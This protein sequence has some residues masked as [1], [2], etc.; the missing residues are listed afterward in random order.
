[1]APAVNSTKT[2]W[3]SQI[4]AIR[5]AVSDLEIEQADSGTKEYGYD[6]PFDEKTLFAEDPQDRIWD[7]SD[8]EDEEYSS[9][10]LE[11]L[12]EPARSAGPSS[13]VFDK[14]WL[15]RCCASYAQRKSGLNAEELVEQVMAVIASDSQG[16]F[17]RS[18]VSGETNEELR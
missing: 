3:S 6:I 15:K 11:D 8:P 10:S 17:L 18:Y 1:M 7:I 16:R 9:D 12:R 2:E 5:Q 14:A 13:T 4:A